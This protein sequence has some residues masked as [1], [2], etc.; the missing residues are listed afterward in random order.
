M[1]AGNQRIQRWIPGAN[2]GTT[3]VTATS[4][5]TPRGMRFD[6]YGNLVVADQNMHRII[7]FTII[8]RKYMYIY[9]YFSLINH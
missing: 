2:F 3:I 4:M 9:L 6:N 7:S 1:D 5:N 8:C